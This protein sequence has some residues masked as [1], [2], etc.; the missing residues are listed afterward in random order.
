MKAVL[1]YNHLYCRK[2]TFYFRCILR[3]HR[4]KFQIIFSLNTSVLIEAIKQWQILNIEIEKLKKLVVHR[5]IHE[6][7]A[8]KSLVNGFKISM[9]KQLKIQNIDPMIA[10]LEQAYND[11]AHT[12][13][14]VGSTPPWCPDY[15]E[16]FKSVFYAIA[17]ADSREIGHNLMVSY[18]N[19]LTTEVEKADFIRFISSVIT[20][21]V[22]GEDPINPEGLILGARR[23]LA[24]HG[25][26]CDEQSVAFRVLLSK[27]ESSTILKHSLINSVS[28]GLSIKE[29]ELTKLISAA[30]TTIIKPTVSDAPL[31]SQVYAEF[32]DHKINKENLAD[33]IQKDYERK[34]S[35][36]NILSEDKAIDMYT[37]QDI[38]KFIDRC[39]E[40]P[41]MNLKPYNKM[42]WPERLD[43][44][45][46]E[47]DLATPKSI[48][49]YYKWLQGIFA[50]AMKDTIG[51]IK[52]TPC[53]I[54]RN[55]KANIRGVFDS[56][57][58]KL[59]LN[60]AKHEEEAWKKW[61]IYLVI[62]T[63]A[64]RGEL[65]QLR[66][67][68][69]KLAPKTGRHYLLITDAHESQKLKTGNSKRKIPLNQVLIDAGF[70]DYVERAKDR[71]FEG[72]ASSEAVTRWFARQMIKLKVGTDNELGHIRSYHSFR[73]TF[74]SNVRNNGA[75]VNLV[76]QVVGHELSKSGITDNY[77]HKTTE[78][79]QLLC[80][81]DVFE[82]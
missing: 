27:L 57:E 72:L 28:N 46:P 41:K 61:I 9:K 58:L 48:S 52:A 19:S 77:T 12:I 3:K 59:F 20:V 78:L 5:Q 40:L 13:N 24:D 49:H 53:T 10:E 8:I 7:E 35:V 56:A 76:Q 14:V 62:Y 11:E 63:G 37:A 15:P 69:V 21:A 26:E 79:G 23:L 50:Y 31:F 65:V 4:I 43:A 39:F 17:H 1:G 25:F 16:V 47:E 66:K 36:W 42:T 30:P 29:R 64:R 32:L 60:A 82:V 18:Y 54:K 6:T 67:E 38:G 22:E 70:L 75:P 51:Y 73:H 33:K 44:D 74:I 80:V 68:D 81:V 2:G 71:V 34:I 45:V 55:F